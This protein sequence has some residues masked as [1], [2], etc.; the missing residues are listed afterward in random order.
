MVLHVIGVLLAIVTAIVFILGVWSMALGGDDDR[1]HSNG[2]MFARVEVQAVA[3]G[4][5][6]LAAYLIHT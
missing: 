2:M 5:M 3:L 4:L 6:A 1:R